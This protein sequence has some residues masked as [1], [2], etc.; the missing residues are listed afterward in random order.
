MPARRARAKEV[1]R[2]TRAEYV[3][4]RF[5]REV[6]IE[7]TKTESREGDGDSFTFSFSSEQPVERWFGNEVLS[8]DATAADFSRLNNGAGPYLWNHNRE[9]VLGRVD[10]AWIDEDRRGY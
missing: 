1:E 4:Q 6:V 10:R 9:V 5:E 7:I 8:H 3:G 2:Q